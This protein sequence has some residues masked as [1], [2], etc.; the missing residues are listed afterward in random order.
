MASM[1]ESDRIVERRC[2]GAYIQ[3]GSSGGL[4]G[5]RMMRPLA[6]V[7]TKTYLQTATKQ[8]FPHMYTVQNCL[9]AVMAAMT[10]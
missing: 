9:F 8:R 2:G 10:V 6:L 4:T 3:G 7:R 1:R 5:K